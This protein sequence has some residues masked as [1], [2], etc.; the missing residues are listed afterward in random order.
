MFDIIIPIY[1]SEQYVEKCIESLENQTFKDF[2]IIAINDHSTDNTFNIVKKLAEKYKNIKLYEPVEKLFNG[3]SRNI[4]IKKSKSK[5]ILFIDNDDWF[6]DENCLQSIYETIQENNEPDLVRL[7]YYCLSGENKQ[8]VL[9]TEDNPKD[10]VNSLYIAPWTK[11]VK[12][13]KV[14]LF[15]ENTLVEDVVQHI[16]QIDNIETIAV[17]EH[18]I[19]VW[20]RNNTQAASLKENQ[21]T[22]LNGKRISS[23]YRNIAD[24]MDLVCK[25]DYCEEHRQWRIEC[26][27]NLVK[28]GKEETF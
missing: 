6:N 18:P 25:H 15:P 28:E 27:K 22:L 4:G 26:Y 24:L 10:L 20:N 14:T 8:L 7:S 9:L 17:C 3:G 19:V 2:N 11:C 16:S 21:K 12:S 13:E 1:N 5:Y 23:I